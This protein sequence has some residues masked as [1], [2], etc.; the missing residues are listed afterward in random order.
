MKLKGPK[1]KQNKNR[2]KKACYF[3]QYFVKKNIPVT[4]EDLG[5]DVYYI[6]IG[7]I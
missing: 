6:I 7:S 3:I 2:N 1:K 5:S 4:F